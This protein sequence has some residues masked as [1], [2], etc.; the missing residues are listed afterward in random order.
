M[1]KHHVGYLRS[2]NE[3]KSLEFQIGTLAYK[4]FIGRI[5]W[6]TMKKQVC[7]CLIITGVFLSYYRRV[8]GG[9]YIKNLNARRRQ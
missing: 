6:V 2:V 5:K 7:F 3:F 9:K 8:I 4:E 1:P